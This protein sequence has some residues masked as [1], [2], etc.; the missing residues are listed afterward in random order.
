M[1]RQ[2]VAQLR[3]K[4]A[5]RLLLQAGYSRQKLVKVLHRRIRSFD[6]RLQIAR[7]ALRGVAHLL[8]ALLDF[9][10][11]SRSRLSKLFAVSR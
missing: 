3:L 9:R 5:E 6:R 8:Q 1:V 11:R 4:F 10:R 2:C 7:S